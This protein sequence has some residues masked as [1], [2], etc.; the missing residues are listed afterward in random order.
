MKFILKFHFFMLLLNFVTSKCSFRVSCARENLTKLTAQIRLLYSSLTFK[1]LAANWK[2]QYT[3]C[4]SQQ[5]IQTKE[6]R[7]NEMEE[8][9]YHKQK[10]E[11][12]ENLIKELK[13][14]VKEKKKLNEIRSRR[15]FQYQRWL[16]NKVNTN[17]TKVGWAGAVHQVWMCGHGWT[18]WKP[19]R[20]R[21]WSSCTQRFRSGRSTNGKTRF[22]SNTQIM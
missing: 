2:S 9:R 6:D 19:Q 1:L 20:W 14:D 4:Y 17:R 5:P 22:P 3:A 15:E 16:W 10:E 12:Y 11:E 7:Q 18:S 21:T 13:H 8:V